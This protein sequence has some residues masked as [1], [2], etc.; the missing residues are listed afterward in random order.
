MCISMS[1]LKH[2]RICISYN[3][4]GYLWQPNNITKT[5]FILEIQQLRKAVELTATYTIPQRHML[6][7]MFRA[8]A[9]FWGYF[10]V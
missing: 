9:T 3:G 2:F 8:T 6:K 5:K 10:I 1:V 7:R 4:N